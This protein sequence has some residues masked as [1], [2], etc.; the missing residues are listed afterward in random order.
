M[1]PE[2]RWRPQPTTGSRGNATTRQRRGCLPFNIPPAEWRAIIT[3][4]PNLLLAGSQSATSAMLLALKPHL[5]RPHWRCQAAK[6]LPLPQLAKGTLIL[7]EVGALAREQ[8]EGLLDCLN[9]I[10][11]GVQIVSTTAT[12][13]FCLVEQGTFLANLYYRLNVMRLDLKV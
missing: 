1:E 2:T 7:C 4:R 6:G 12:P 13:I 5:A 8:Q 11:E 9:H 10:E 3:A